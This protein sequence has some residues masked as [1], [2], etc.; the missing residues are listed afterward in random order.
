MYLNGHCVCPIVKF[1]PIGEEV[2]KSFSGRLRLEMS[3][4]NNDLVNR[5]VNTDPKCSCGY[6]K[7]TAEHYF[8]HC[9]NYSNTRVSR[10]LTLPICQTDSRTLLCSNLDPLLPENKHIFL[11]VQEFILLAKRL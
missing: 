2:H 3:N 4:L 11:A 7:E 10:V 1:Q 6:S 9:P 8:L 5:Y